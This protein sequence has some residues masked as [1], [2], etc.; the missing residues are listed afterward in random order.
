MGRALFQR[1]RGHAV[2]QRLQHGQVVRPAVAGDLPVAGRAQRAVAGGAQQHL[3]P[4][5]RRRA[6]RRAE[7]LVAPLVRGEQR[8]HLRV[9]R[10][11]RR[12]LPAARRR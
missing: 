4:P 7:A 1:R 6:E 9:G 3:G 10:I 2:D 12:E 8:Q 5:G 11:G